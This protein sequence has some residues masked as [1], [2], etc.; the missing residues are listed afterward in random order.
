MFHLKF[1]V[2]TLADN[3]ENL[4]IGTILKKCIKENKE[5]REKNFI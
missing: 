4:E 5:K 3:I 2:Y 1:L